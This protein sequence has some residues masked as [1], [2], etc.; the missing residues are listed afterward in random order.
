[1]TNSTRILLAILLFSPVTDVSANCRL[2]I[3]YVGKNQIGHILLFSSRG[4]GPWHPSLKSDF[5]G[6]SG[7]RDSYEITQFAVGFEPAA[8]EIVDTWDWNSTKG[9]PRILRVLADGVLDGN[10]Y[11]LIV[12]ELLLTD[13]Q[14]DDALARYPEAKRGICRSH[15]SR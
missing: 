8:Q 14:Y 3:G 9:A 2:D 5:W 6:V 10:S 15:F 13:E 11:R 12:R 4:G 7:P 1:M